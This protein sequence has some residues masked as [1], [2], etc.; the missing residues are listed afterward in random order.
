MRNKFLESITFWV[1]I[2]YR[3]RFNPECNTERCYIESLAI[4]LGSKEYE[5]LCGG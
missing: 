1:K 2:N 3:S 5:L 4:A